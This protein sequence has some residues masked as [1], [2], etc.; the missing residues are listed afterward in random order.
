[1]LRGTAALATIQSITDILLCGSYLPVFSG[2]LT[3]TR[4][5]V[6]SAHPAK[7]NYTEMETHP[8]KSLNYQAYKDKEQHNKSKSAVVRLV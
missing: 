7:I 5:C 8:I 1:M 2:L 4:A 6:W 3:G